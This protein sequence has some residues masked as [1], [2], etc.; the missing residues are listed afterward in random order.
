MLERLPKAFDDGVFFWVKGGAGDQN[1]KKKSGL[2]LFSPVLPS[3]SH[4]CF[5]MVQLR[6]PHLQSGVN[7]QVLQQWKAL[8]RSTECPT[9]RPVSL[10]R[11]H[12][13]STYGKQGKPSLPGACMK[14][15]ANL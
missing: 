7:H 2:V 6:C 14:D 15:M 11:L 10:T 5:L 13:F 8:L 9:V 1:K 3:S 12:S 4:F